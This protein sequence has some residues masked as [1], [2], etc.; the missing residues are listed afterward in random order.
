MVGTFPNTNIVDTGDLFIGDNVTISPFT[1]IICKERIF[2]GSNVQIGPSVTI[3]DFDHDMTDVERIMLDG[4]KL[5][6]IIEDNCWIGANSVILKGVY[7][8]KGC[9]VGA[10]SVVTKPF[11]ANSI[12]AGN[13]ARFIRKRRTPWT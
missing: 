13:P 12:I 5:P 10:G 3:V 2:I 4:E 1:S 9:V 11:A 6:V 7:L 8:G